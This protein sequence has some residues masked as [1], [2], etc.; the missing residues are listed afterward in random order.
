M[1]KDFYILLI[2]V[3]AG[4][5]YGLQAY[6]L[7]NLSRK[8]DGLTISM[9]RSLSFFI[10][11]LPL[12]FLV[13]FHEIIKILNY[14][15]LIII[16]GFFG[17][18]GSIFFFQAT[19]YL[20]MGIASSINQSFIIL[21]FLWSYLFLGII[22]ETKLYVYSL[23]ILIG[24]VII[25]TCKTKSMNKKGLLYIILSIIF[26]SITIFTIGI[27]SKYNNPIVTGIIWELVIG[28][29][30]LLIYYFRKNTKKEF[31]TSLFKK[32]TLY[33]SPTVIG[34]TLMPLSVKYFGTG[35]S[36]LIING[37]STLTIIILSFIIIKEKISLKQ[38]VGVFTIFLG[39]ALINIF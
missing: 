21:V 27:V 31:N 30:L 32:I 6:L 34:S 7:S 19:K 29:F 2:P 11:F 4:I 1:P 22:L 28:V 37:V 25:N 12:I 20:P 3:I 16:S 14:W 8:L 17:A 24:I 35:I 26:A 18:F 13:P 39:V 15:E 36:N 23:I 5:S 10:T 33:A 9:Y 38:T